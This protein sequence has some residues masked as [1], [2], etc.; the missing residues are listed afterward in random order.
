MSEVSY[1]THHN[2]TNPYESLFG[3]SRGVRKGPF[4]FISGTTSTSTPEPSSESQT[5]VILYPDSA[6]EQ[7]L[8]IFRTIIHSVEYLGGKRED[9]S[10]IRMF[11][12]DDADSNDIGRALKE[13]LSDVAP[14]ATMIIGAA[15][16]NPAMKV[17]IEADAVVL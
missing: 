16:V 13:S 1:P 10:R 17:E 8:H 2:T 14:A 6:Y 4:I 15:F 9:I 5:P 3:Y 11:V 12:R 7:A